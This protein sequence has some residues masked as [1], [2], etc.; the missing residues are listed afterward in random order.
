MTI[1][2]TQALDLIYSHTK[3]TKTKL[4][5]IENALGYVLAEDI[6]ATH[7]LPP[8]DNSAMDGYA[9]KLLASNTRIVKGSIFA[10]DSGDFSLKDNEALKIMTGGKIPNGCDAVV[11]IEHVESSGDTI[12][13]TKEPKEDQNIRLMAED[14]TAGYTLLARGT[15]LMAHHIML[16]ASQGISHINVHKKP[17]VAVFASGNE[18]KMHFESVEAHQLYNTNTIATQMRSYELGCEVEFLG[19][20]KDSIKDFGSFIDSALGS[21]L[22]ITTG[23]VS[24]GDADL[25]KESFAN[26]GHE[27]YFDSVEIK[28]GKPTTFG[29]IGDTLILNLPGNPLAAM[30]CYEIFA[31][32]IILALSGSSSKFINPLI[33]PLDGEYSNRSRKTSLIPGNFD[34][35]SFKPL[36]KVSSGMVRPI[37]IA[38]SFMVISKECSELKKG[39]LV[40]VIPTRFELNSPMQTSLLNL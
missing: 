22:I 18:L 14:I 12:T 30:L 33:V 2:I 13:I 29:R 17:R 8:Y 28:P 25:T 36:P 15:K 32:S 39:E 16:L 35:K 7:N 26:F 21:D 9:I 5:P 11:P 6:I 4:L 19:T 3:A 31:R 40:K 37:A 20:A 38:D 24:V 1:T 23:G 27:I 10:G 34:G